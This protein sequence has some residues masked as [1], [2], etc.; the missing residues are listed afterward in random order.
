MAAGWSDFAERA[1]NEWIALGADVDPHT[2]RVGVRLERVAR[3]HETMLN[4][5]LAAFRPQGLRGMEDFRLLAFLVRCRPQTTSATAASR[6][7][8][9][10]K[11]ATSARIERFVADGLAER[12]ASQHDKRT[13]EVQASDAGV[14]LAKTTVEAVAQVHVRLLEGLDELELKTLD[15]AL[16]DITTRFV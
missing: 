3:R 14:E 15:V 7:L 8:G 1:T 6:I 9:L 10:S 12:S 4:N 5:A 13:V 16:A 11:A 2:F